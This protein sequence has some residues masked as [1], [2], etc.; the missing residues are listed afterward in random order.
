MLSLYRACAWLH[1]LQYCFQGWCRP[2]W[3]ANSHFLSI[4]W[5]YVPDPSHARPSGM[6]VARVPGRINPHVPRVG[7]LSH[8][9]YL[10]W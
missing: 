2:S 5:R 4:G 9:L 3:A 7:V 10:N 1:D 8:M 6:A